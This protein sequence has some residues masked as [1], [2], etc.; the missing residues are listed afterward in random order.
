ME[1]GL[2]ANGC[3]D[4]VYFSCDLGYTIKGALAVT[5]GDDGSWSSEQPACESELS[6]S[7]VHLC[8][9]SGTPLLWTPWGPG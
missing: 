9:E 4:T 5:C 1:P 6:V 7:V 3:Q 8:E 2:H